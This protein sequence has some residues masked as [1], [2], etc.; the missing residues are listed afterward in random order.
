MAFANAIEVTNKSAAHKAFQLFI[1]YLR[2]LHS[3][4]ENGIE[5]HLKRSFGLRAMLHAESEHHNLTLASSKADCS[6]FALQPLRPMRITGDQNVLGIIGEPRDD[7]SL[8][9]RRSR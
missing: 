9:V 1:G 6:R 4:P 2:N 8:D 7:R 5:Q 3:C